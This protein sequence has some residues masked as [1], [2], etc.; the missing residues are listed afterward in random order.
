MARSTIVSR[1]QRLTLAFG[2]YLAPA[3]CA[4]L[5]F[6]YWPFFSS[7]ILSFF[8]WNFVSSMRWVGVENYV[9]MAKREAFVRALKNTFLYIFGLF[10]FFGILPLTFAVALEG[11]RS[12][13]V[14]DFVKA[15]VFVPSILSF[16]V[17]CL[18]WMWM[19]NP[20]FGV[21][22]NLIRLF[23]GKGFAW[24]S[25][26]RTAMLS[27]ILVSGWK[28]IGANMILFF[29][30]LACI[31]RECVEA[32]TIDGASRWQVFWKIKWPLLAPTTIY[33]V[34]TSA[35]FAAERAFIPINI[36]TKGGPANAT[37]N[38]SHIIYVFGFEFFNIGLASATAIVTS[39][40]FLIITRALLRLSGGFGY[41][42]N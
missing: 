4:F 26:S 13:K 41:Y 28:N 33:V 18:V 40:M 5:L 8:R 38:L 12:R 24:L 3:V 39:V 16:A 9:E 35:I 27:I 1:K 14:R 34:V 20:E 7:L 36:L 25:D 29:A 10:P 21:F 19:F 32:A 17:I 6:K 42:E 22:N 15:L 11:I 30:G 23:G 31:P 37:T 2:L